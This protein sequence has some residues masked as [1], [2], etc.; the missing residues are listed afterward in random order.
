MSAVRVLSSCSYVRKY[1]VRT[2]VGRH[3]SPHVYVG[4]GRLV[5]PRCVPQVC[6][7]RVFS[8]FERGPGKRRVQKPSRP[9][10]RSPDAEMAPGNWLCVLTT[11]LGPGCGENRNILTRSIFW[12]VAEPCQNSCSLW[13]HFRTYVCSYVPRAGG[14]TRHGKIHEGHKP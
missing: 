13:I 4:R 9:E 6:S 11:V 7:R 5:F 1:H 3:C 14:P 2:Y 10:S 12:C 8:A